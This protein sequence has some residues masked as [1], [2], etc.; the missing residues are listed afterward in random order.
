MLHDRISRLFVQHF[1][2]PPAAILEIAGDGSSRSYFRLITD[3]WKT[4]VGGI[5]P[6]REE[7]RAF[8]SYSRSL[9]GAG[10][11]V[12]E[13][14]GADEDAGV[15]L[16]QDLGDLTLFDALAEARDREGGVFPR[17]ILPSYRR[18]LQEL[19]RFQVV[20][21][22]A[23]DYSVAYPRSAFDRQ[24]ILW[25]LNYF[26]YHFLKL[27]H[28]PFSEARLE[29]DFDRLTDFLL[30]ADGRHFLYRD[31]QSRN[32]M[33]QDGEP[34]FIDYQGG[35]RGAL[36][37]DVASLLYDAKAG[38]P[39]DVRDELLEHYLDALEE[40]VAFDREDFRQ[41]YRGFVLVRIMQAMGAYGYRGFFERKPRFLQSVPYAA[42]NLAVL[43]ERGLPVRLP[44]LR[45][46]YRRIVDTW[47]E[48]DETS[49]EAPGLTVHVGSFSYRRG[50][51][52]DQGGHGGGYVFD[53]RALPNPGRHLEYRDLCGRDEDVVRFIEETPE[54]ADFWNG[55]TALVDAQVE[56]YLRRGFH[57]LTVMFGCTGGQHRSVYFAERLARHLETFP[58]TVR[59]THR[60]EPH[61]PQHRAA[62][63]TA[64]E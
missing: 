1:G 9:R 53:C 5:G 60:E 43:L 49:G 32:V 38:I 41:H 56:E 58:V 55:V 30:E 13:I 47:S 25:D 2:S 27:A 51:P 7:N 35:R 18:V 8:L 62:S 59:L 23:V 16:E 15:W 24:S 3:D 64:R 39:D 12:P 46:V 61:W 44:E 22:D 14:F 20:G 10:L 26:K 11:N 4:A 36:Q 45:R 42:R 52:D 37:Y 21:G 34:W 6:D 48:Q 31:F 54:A 50:Y 33:L 28:V 40:Y 19:P 29:D 63:A 57:S 17:S